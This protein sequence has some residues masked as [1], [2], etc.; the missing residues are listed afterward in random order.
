[1]SALAVPDEG[2]PRYRARR[3]AESR[4]LEEPEAW[5]LRGG[6]GLTEEERAALRAE[7]GSDP[8]KYRRLREGRWLERTEA[9]AAE[10]R[11]APEYAELRAAYG[12][13]DG[14]LDEARL[15][16]AVD[17][18]LGMTCGRCGRRTGNRTQGHHWAY[19]RVTGTVRDHHFCCPGACALEAGTVT[20]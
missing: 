11:A 18:S 13:P 7:L 4:T 2:Y 12:A 20:A 10:L 17:R 6:P 14:E 3:E 15:L 1:V 16:D 9:E 5:P 8:E 19:C